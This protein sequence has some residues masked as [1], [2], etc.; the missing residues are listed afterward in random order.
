MKIRWTA[1]FTRSPTL[2]RDAVRSWNYGMREGG[3]IATGDAA[4]C[5]AADAI[6]AGKIVAIKGLGGFHLVVDARN[7][8]TVTRLRERKRREEKP[9]ALMAPSLEEIKALCEVSD[10]EERLLLAPEAPIVLLRRNSGSANRAVSPAVA[11]RNPYLGI[12]LPYTPLHHLFMRELGFFIVATSAN[13]SDEPIC[14]DEG[15][16]GGKAARH[17]RFVSYP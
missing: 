9:F 17:C 12:M 1:A 15:R 5:E 3:V 10:F 13:L 2:A 16:G 11:P 8:L 6:R 7:D 14:T 4:F